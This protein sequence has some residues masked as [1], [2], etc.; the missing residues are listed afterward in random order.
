M[1]VTVGPGCKR[2]T[3]PGTGSLSLPLAVLRPG[4]VTGSEYAGATGSARASESASGRSASA[5]GRASANLP[6]KG[7]ARRPGLSLPVSS[8]STSHWHTGTHTGT[9]TK[10]WQ[11]ELEW[12]K[13]YSS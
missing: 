12:L 11:P 7:L 1:R 5:P 9:H 8:T 6:V 3:G 10:H 13:Y 4:P 2:A